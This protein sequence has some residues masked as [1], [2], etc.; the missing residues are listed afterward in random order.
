MMTNGCGHNLLVVCDNRYHGYPQYVCALGC[1][2]VLTGSG[3][4]GNPDIKNCTAVGGTHR[5]AVRVSGYEYAAKDD[6]DGIKVECQRCWV[7]F[8]I[9]YEDHTQWF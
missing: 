2:T 7:T 4:D 9:D 3:P 8:N 5:I 6:G 1:R